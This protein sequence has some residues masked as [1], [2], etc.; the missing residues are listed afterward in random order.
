MDAPKEIQDLISRSGNSFHAKT[1]RWFQASGWHIRVS[2]YYMD[3]SQNKAR[4][5]DLVAEK[6]FEVFTH[7]VHTAYVVIRLFIECKFVPSYAVFWTTTK[8]LS[9]AEGLVC[10]QGGFKKNNNY[11]RKHHYLAGGDRVAKVFASKPDIGQ[12]SEP[13]YKA[14]NQVLNAYVSMRYGAVASPDLE[15]FRGRRIVINYPVVVCSSFEK[16]YQTD[17]YGAS[18]PK[19]MDENFQL[20]VQYA[21]VDHGG[22]SRDDYFLID[23]IEFDRL[24]DFSNAIKVD[25]E[26]AAQFAGRKALLRD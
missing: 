20:E 24:S 14:L 7:H 13:F 10:S 11:T 22:A 9:A 26:A 2:P 25:G 16:I 5:I 21:Y 3:Q 23:F 4:E 12:E 1:A 8:D 17:F 6:T 18:A 15:G 19:Q